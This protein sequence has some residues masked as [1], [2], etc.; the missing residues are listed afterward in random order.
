MAT[1]SKKAQDTTQKMYS[2]KCKGGVVVKV[3]EKIIRQSQLLHNM[4]V[5]SDD[6]DSML[7]VSQVDSKVLKSI[8]TFLE[9]YQNEKPYKPAK[10]Y[11]V[12]ISP[13]DDQFLAN[14]NGNQL[15][16]LLNTANYLSVYRLIDAGCLRIR[17]MIENRTA[18]E[19][20]H[21]LQ[22]PDDLTDEEKREIERVYVDPEQ[23]S[24]SST[25]FP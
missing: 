17:G 9:P 11:R 5:L 19:I 1:T 4:I 23:P 25:F 24:T 10:D 3:P 12:Q 18:E 13:R 7:N 15:V 21:I 20:R 22:L 6:K 14:F 8:I 2:V 16:E